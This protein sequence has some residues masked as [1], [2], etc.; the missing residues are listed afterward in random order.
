MLDHL[1]NGRFEIG[2]GRGVSPFELAYYG[3]SFM[4]S[5]EIFD[6]ALDVIVA[7]L[8]GERLISPRSAL[9]FDW[10]ADGIDAEAAAESAILVRR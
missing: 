10:S 8:R 7:G 2:V 3:I 5:R 1:S 6:E 9:S 4:D